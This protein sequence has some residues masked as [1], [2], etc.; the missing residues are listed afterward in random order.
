MFGWAKSFILLDGGRSEMKYLS[1]YFICVLKSLW[2]VWKDFNQLKYVHRNKM[3]ELSDS[4]NQLI[5]L[6]FENCPIVC[7]S[8]FRIAET[9][10]MTE[11]NGN[12]GANEWT[13]GRMYNVY[14]INLFTLLRYT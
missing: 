3:V 1:T 12:A 5:S 2:V 11:L 4:Q 10:H 9:I 13:D 8:H 7:L 14:A 6:I